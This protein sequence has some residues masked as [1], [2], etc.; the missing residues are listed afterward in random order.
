MSWARLSLPAG[1]GRSQ[2]CWNTMLGQARC[3]VRRMS[4]R[5]RSEASGQL[6]STSK[7]QIDDIT[8]DHGDDLDSA[9]DRWHGA[10]QVGGVSPT[11]REIPLYGP[12]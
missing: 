4:G 11:K 7:P 3:Q 2:A 5:H 9:M 6:L 12:I 1:Q 8:V 10:I